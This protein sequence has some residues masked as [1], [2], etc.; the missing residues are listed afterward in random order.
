MLTHPAQEGNRGN[1]RGSNASLKH[2]KRQAA[3]AVSATTSGLFLLTDLR[4]GVR[5]LGFE[6]LGNAEVADLESVMRGQ[7]DIR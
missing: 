5:L 4:L 6:Q 7:K 3:S 2:V 1:G